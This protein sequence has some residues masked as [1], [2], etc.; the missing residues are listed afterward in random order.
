L[1]TVLTKS[2]IQAVLQNETRIYQ[3]VAQILYGSRLPL[4]EALCLWVKN[5]DF[6]QQQIIVRNAKDWERK[7]LLS[8]VEATSV[9]NRATTPFVPHLD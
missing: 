8:P 4:N 7:L 2:E 1:P 6:A 3:L 9:W 5:V